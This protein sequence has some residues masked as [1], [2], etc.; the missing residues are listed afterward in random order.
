MALLSRKNLLGQCSQ[1]EGRS[2]NLH[3]PG[4]CHPVS[5]SC[6]HM[7]QWWC[8]YHGSLWMGHG[9]E[10]VR[11]WVSRATEKQK[12]ALPQGTL[13][14]LPRFMSPGQP[15][16]VPTSE[17]KMEHRLT[18]VLG[19]KNNLGLST[20]TAYTQGI[21][22]HMPM[23]VTSVCDKASVRKIS[24]RESRQETQVRK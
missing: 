4:C 11:L 13:L 18:S 21:A 8:V 15:V 10:K 1:G 23:S 5:V 24:A 16:H 12:C 19:T 17:L 7:P 2:G 3:C 22:E 20:C 6:A 14:G 9:S